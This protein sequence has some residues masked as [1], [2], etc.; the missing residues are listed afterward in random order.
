MVDWVVRESP[1]GGPTLPPGGPI[2]V[3]PPTGPLSGLTQGGT[4]V[5]TGYPGVG[6]Q[7]QICQM[8]P[9]GWQRTLCQMGLGFLSGGG[10]GPGGLT[11]QNPCE[12]GFVRDPITGQCTLVP[13]DATPG[14]VTP[15][16]ASVGVSG[17]LLPS[18]T[19]VMTHVCPKYADGKKGIL[20]MNALSGQVVCLPRGV[21]GRGF[22]LIRKNKPRKKPYISAAEK[23]HLDIHSR[24]KKKA[25][26][27]ASKAG[28]MCKTRGSG[29]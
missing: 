16:E 27:F 24:V 18:L 26:E 2:I 25:K 8:L 22:G 1:G 28:Y 12:P 19:P 10:T 5:P 9:E 15:A 6:G 13:S 21:N 14:T 20:W 29:R 17:V 7:Q 23:R 4:G 3:R 11:T